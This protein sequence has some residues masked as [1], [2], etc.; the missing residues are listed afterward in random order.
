MAFK[1]ESYPVQFLKITRESEAKIKSAILWIRKYCEQ[2]F[3][4][5]FKYI[6]RFYSGNKLHSVLKAM[7]PKFIEWLQSSFKRTPEWPSTSRK[8]LYQRIRLW[9]E[10]ETVIARIVQSVCLWRAECSA[11]LWYFSWQ[12]QHFFPTSLPCPEERKTSW[13][14]TFNRKYFQALVEHKRSVFWQRKVPLS[15]LRFF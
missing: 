11:F 12:Q 14:K 1:F 4:V 7:Q 15:R 13:G 5:T 8:D 2:V 6:N 3:F 9:I 10:K